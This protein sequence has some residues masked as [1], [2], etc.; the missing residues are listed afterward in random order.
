MMMLPPKGPK[1]LWPTIPQVPFSGKPFK[2]RYI[3]KY[4]ILNKR[5]YS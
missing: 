5:G 3:K 2:K 4:I 1:G